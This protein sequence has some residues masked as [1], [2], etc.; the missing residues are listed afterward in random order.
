M[1]AKITITNET[2]KHFDKKT[3]NFVTKGGVAI[4]DAPLLFQ[5]VY[6][7]CLEVQAV[8]DVWQRDTSL[9][10]A[11]ITSSQIETLVLRRLVA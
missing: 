4:C 9:V 6:A 11:N 3:A 1:A 8:E 10:D 7:K 5:Y 2:T